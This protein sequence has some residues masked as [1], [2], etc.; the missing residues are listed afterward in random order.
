VTPHRLVN[1]ETL[2]PP[3]G[4]AHA[5]AAAPG[6]VVALAG[7]VAQDA[8]GVVRGEDV[9]EQF[10]RAAANVV[11][12]LAA[13]GGSPEHLVSLQVFTTDLAAYRASLTALGEAYRRAFGRH[14]PAMAVIG[15]PEL[16]DPAA[17]VELVGVAVV[18]EGR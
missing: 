1:P 5:V 6:R 14:Y 8:D 7:Q 4:Y 10:G 12:A 18:P 9:V 2:A 3:V 17:L 16:F 11:T 13:A 15:V